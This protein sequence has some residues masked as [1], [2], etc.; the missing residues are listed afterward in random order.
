MHADPC[1]NPAAGF[2]TSEMYSSDPAELIAQAQE[3]EAEASQLQ[4]KDL[5]FEARAKLL[6]AGSLRELAACCQQQQ[7]RHS[8]SQ[9][10]VS[11]V[12]GPLPKLLAWLRSAS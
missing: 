11:T 7:S 9:K 6:E 12:E 2:K 5:P 8:Y 4:E 1:S 10:P 3:L